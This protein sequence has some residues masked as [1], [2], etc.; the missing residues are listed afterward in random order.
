MAT[1]SREFIPEPKRED[2]LSKSVPS[3]LHPEPRVVNK[4][5]KVTGH[6]WDDTLTQK[7]RFIPSRP[8]KSVGS[9]PSSLLFC[10][11]MN[12]SKSNRI[13]KA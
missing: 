2:Y 3:R 6:R 8:K 1:H 12:T 7:V 10:L 5:S 13:K 11:K 4:I 9:C